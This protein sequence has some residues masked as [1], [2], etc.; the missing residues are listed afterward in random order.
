MIDKLVLTRKFFRET[1]TIIET[2]HSQGFTTRRI[3]CNNFEH[4]HVIS[5]GETF[6]AAIKFHPRLPSGNDISLETNPSRFKTL[7]E[8]RTAFSPIVDLSTMKISRID[9]AA[10]LP[11]S[12]D[13]AMLWTRVT[14]KR[15]AAEYKDKGRLTG[16]DFGKGN[17]FISIYDRAFEREQRRKYRPIPGET[18]GLCTRFEVRKKGR[19]I[20]YRE[21]GQL[22][23]YLEVD[24]FEGIEFYQVPEELPSSSRKSIRLNY[25]RELVHCYG[26]NRAIKLENQSS[27]FSKTY[28]PLLV[29]PSL[30]KQLTEIYRNNLSNFFQPGGIDERPVSRINRIK[31]CEIFHN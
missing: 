5:R 6:I 17:E 27:N 1:P 14:H 16:F 7:A 9:L 18:A 24:P 2:I 28:K 8:Y 20:P 23:L 22:H 11:I 10:D 13:Q 4:C 29:Q 19:K 30:N 26:L 3:P 25:F 12:I 21:V 15:M 31:E